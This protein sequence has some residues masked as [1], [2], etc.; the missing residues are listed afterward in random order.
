MDDQR[1][2][3]GLFNDSFPP[4]L[5]GVT[6]TVQNYAKWLAAQNQRVCVI[7]PW[8]PYDFPHPEFEM[9]RYFSVPLYRR[10]PYRYG[11]PRLDPLIWWWLRRLPFKIVHAHCPFSSGRL[12]QYAARR[13]DI[14][15]V[16][17][18]HSKYQTDLAR[19]LSKPMLKFQMRR[20][21]N[22]YNSV[23][24]LWIPQ[25]A[26]EETVREY[27]ITAPVAVVDNGND[28]YVADSELDAVK[29]QARM[30]MAVPEGRLMLLFVGQHIK[31]KGVDV[32]I[33]ALRLLPE[34]LDWQMH[35]VGNGY[36]E[37][38]MKRRV[39]S[40]NLADRVVFHGVI[41]D[42][43][44]LRRI[45]A[46]A[47]LFLFPSFYDN[48]PLVV[49]EAAALGTPAVLLEGSTAAEVITHGQNGFLSERTPRA[50]ADAIMQ[51]HQHPDILRE[52]QLGAR[53]SLCRS[54]RNVMEEVV[55]R[56]NDI[57]CRYE[58]KRRK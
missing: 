45:Y 48:A 18:F 5:D 6:L 11:Y 53:S 19:V 25:A 29:R 13:H 1:C 57:I 43:E 49:R 21:R 35:F 14:P 3:Y 16:A 42:R 23:D 10:H 52:M 58:S 26:V 27:G 12:A 15:L 34:S 32:I 54:W 51:I 17:T 8:D 50:Y 24:A 55:E 56:Y 40:L 30:D 33:D 4:A 31:E 22:F 39:A 37:G 28:F 44:G 7:T 20:I 9:H 36:A 41:G 38:E 47:D 2:V 46:A